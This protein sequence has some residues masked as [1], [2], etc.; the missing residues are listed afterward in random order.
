MNI[1]VV[2]SGGLVETLQAGSLV[3]TLAHA[4]GA[5]I[6]VACPA[7]AASVAHDMSCVGEV[8]S[9][10]ALAHGGGGRLWVELRRRRVDVAMVCS[11]STQV[12]LAT[13]LAGVPR[14][15]GVTAGASDVLLTDRVRSERGQNRGLAWLE[16]ARAIGVEAPPA[17]PGTGFEPGQA[18]RRV[19][20]ELLLSNG[21]EN[22]RLLVAIA[23]GR[24]FSEG[25]APAWPAERFAH[26]ANRLASRHGAGIV[27]IGDD[28][29]RAVAEAMRLDLVG[30]AVDLTGELGLTTA[31]AV[32]ARCDLLV[33]A[34]TPLLHLAAAVGTASVGLFASTSGRQ[35]APAGGEHRVLQALTDGSA[36][37]S[38]DSIRVDDVLAGIESTL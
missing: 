8:L 24:A 6:P 5:P 3:S 18:A 38:L 35:R 10:P 33:A 36:S 23:P 17:P 14:R 28:R 1:V 27:L 20:E 21:V 19:A 26:L 34:D 9:I 25:D 15:V 16:L 11:A 30:G 12:R 4:T 13:Y 32:V 7:A 31:A 29:D 37:A 22:G 2:V